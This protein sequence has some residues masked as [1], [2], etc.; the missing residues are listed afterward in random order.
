MGV[1]GWRGHTDG[2]FI[3]NCMI[4]KLFLCRDVWGVPLHVR[5]GDATGADAIVLAWCL[6]NGVSHHVFR[7][8][9]HPSGAL[10]L[11]AGPQRNEEMLRGYRDPTP[12]ATQLLL[13]FP[14]TDGKRDTVPG[15]GTWGCCISAALMGIKVE[16][17][18]YQRS[19]E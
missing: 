10:M 13:G 17:P 8:R 4:E 1:T 5:V 11:G 14:R 7:A 2:A 19:G 18:A 12:G 3:R 15:S 9:R 6:D 16:I